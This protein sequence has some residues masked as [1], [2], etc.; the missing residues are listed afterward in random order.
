MLP[1]R[2]PAVESV[3]PCSVHMEEVTGG[4]KR[5]GAKPPETKHCSALNFKIEL[6]VGGTWVAQ[7]FKCLTSAQ[8][9]ISR[10]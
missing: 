9:M 1:G 8:V 2:D 7:L 6:G 4:K 3:I 10:S 5:G